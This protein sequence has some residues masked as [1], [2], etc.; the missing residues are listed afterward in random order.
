M[1][2]L[3]RA[4]LIPLF[5]LFV[6]FC[7]TTKGFTQIIT[8][9]ILAKRGEAIEKNRFY[10]LEEYLKKRTSLP[11]EFRY[12]PFEELKK[13]ALEGRLSFII[14]NSY[15]AILIKELALKKGYSYKIILS[16]GQYELGDYYPYFGGV[17]FTR[18]DVPIQSLAELKGKP[19]GAANPDSFGGYLIGLY[20]LHKAGVKEEDL[21]TKFYGTHDAV[22]HAVLKGEVLAGTVRTGILERMAKDGK[23]NLDEIK[24]LSPKSYPNFPLLISS[25][26]Y[27]EWPVLANANLPEKTL[28][29]FARLLLEIPPD[30]ELAKS[31]EAVFFLPQDYSLINQLMLELMKGPYEELK[32]F[33]FQRFWKKYL[34]YLFALLIIF[35]ALLSYLTYNLYLKNRELKKTKEALE[36]E[37]NF[38]DTVL[39][40]TDH[41]IF[42]LDLAGNILWANQKGDRVCVEELGTKGLMNIK[43]CTFAKNL[44]SISDYFTNQ[45]YQKEDRYNFVET[46]EIDGFEKTYEGELVAVKKDGKV[47]SVLLFL[48]D[49]TEKSIMER[50]KIYLEKLNVLK[51]VA[52]G[53]AHDFNNLLS[54]VFNRLELMRLKLQPSFK[55]EEISKLYNELSQSLNQLKILGRELLTLVRGEPTKK[56]KVNPLEL[57]KEYTKLALAGRS[58]YQVEYAVEEGLPKVEVD[59][60]LFSIMWINL[61]L[62]AFE[63]MP[64]GGK[65]VIKL[66]TIEKNGQK[67]VRFEVIDQGVGIPEKHLPQVFEPFFTTKPSGTG[68]GLYVAKEVVTSHGGEINIHS[69]EGEGTRV[70]ILLPAVSE[71]EVLT[72]TE[73]EPLSQRKRVLVMDDDDLVRGSLRELLESLGYEVETAPDGEIAY[74]L[75]EESLQAGKPYDFVVLD[76][77]VPGK[78][79]G[80]DTYMEIKKIYPQVKAIVMSGYFTEPVL[81]D[82]KKYNFYGALTK[83]FPIQDLLKLLES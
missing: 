25:P 44:K 73:V 1:N 34:P 18:K 7:L 26:L 75:F 2:R 62:N 23:I 82:Y 21:K 17:I 3:F 36:R 66:S 51:N 38:L 68:L 30:S 9:G 70:E 8:F 69:K 28:K 63:A 5:S 15:Q 56:E 27:P 54:S 20:E 48:R 19:F 58:N 81:R 52:G 61:C 71:E 83:P 50:Q 40:Y 47:A 37:A 14:T 41:M 24:V 76:L 72:K 33:Y 78:W 39:R 11:I 55:S 45:L 43:E 80:L 6:C 65:V 22:V 60:E 32:G 53:L 16:L 49:I 12:L 74:K 35:L 79:T 42:Q 77:I 64:K 67:F 57:V 4:L 46:V 13:E 59:R 29:E 31:I 10:P